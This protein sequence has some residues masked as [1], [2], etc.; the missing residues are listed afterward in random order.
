MTF[1]T[2]IDKGSMLSMYV[3]SVPME[4]GDKLYLGFHGREKRF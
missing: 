1:H 2:N 4:R 3:K